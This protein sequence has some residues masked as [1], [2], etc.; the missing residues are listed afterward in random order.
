MSGERVRPKRVAEMIQQELSLLIQ[1]EIKDPRLRENIIT[2][3][4]VELTSDLRYA[5]VYFSVLDESKG[6]EVAD[7]FASA[8]GFIRR[9]MGSVLR[10]RFVPEIKYLLDESLSYGMKMQKL[11]ADANNASEQTQTDDQSEQP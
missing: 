6:R 11:I 9:H 10:L 7:A 1:Y 4:E 8:A 2:V 5:T 3:T